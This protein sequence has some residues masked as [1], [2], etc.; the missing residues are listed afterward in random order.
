MRPTLQDMASI[1]NLSKSTVSRALAGDP[2]VAEATRSRVVALAEQIGYRPNPI[3]QGLATRRTNVIGLAVPCAPRSLSD[4]FYLEFLG[5]AGDTAMRYGYSLLLCAAERDG[6]GGYRSHMELA[7]PARIDG[8]IL[9]EPKISDERIEILKERNLPFVFL[10]MAENPDV[11]WVSG[12]NTGGAVSAVARLIELGHTKIACVTGP[13]DQTASEARFKGYSAALAEAG[14]PLDRNIVASGDF[15]QAGGCQAM[16]S[17]LEHGSD[18]SAVFASNDV[19]AFGVMR[20][21]REAGLVIPD[22]VSVLGFDGIPLT[23][24]MD[25]SLA[26]MRQPILELGRTIVEVLVEQMNGKNLC[27]IHK[28]LNVEFQPGGSIAPPHRAS[29]ERRKSHYIR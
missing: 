8:M 14:I 16:K 12:E 1:L 15:T 11:S 10:G 6:A 19:M 3:A 28:V 29:K 4:P 2:R 27:P 17:I 5:A 23:H 24:Y 26:T 7:D 25:P 9:T 13:F 22:D 21:L 20:A 18:F